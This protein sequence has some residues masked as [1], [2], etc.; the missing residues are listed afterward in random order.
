MPILAAPYTP[1]ALPPVVSWDGFAGMTWTGFNGDQWDLKGSAVSPSGV[2]LQRGARGLH[3]PQ[4]NRYSSSSPA[5]AGSRTRGHHTGDRDVFW[6][7]KVFRDGGSQAWMEYDRRFWATMA[8]DKP[9]VWTVIHPDGQARSL[10]CT[11]QHDG[12]GSFAI[13]PLLVGWA[14]YGL[15][16][17]A[18]QPYWEGS[19]I[20]R[21]WKASP[22]VDFFDPAGSPPFHIS[23]GSTFA[24]AVID[25]PGDVEAYP[26]WVLTGPT[27]SVAVGVDGHVVEYEVAIPEGQ[28]RTIDTR[29]DRL[30]VV[31]QDGVDRIDDLGAAEFVAVPAG[32]SVALDVAV[33]GTGMVEATIR[34]LFYR[35]W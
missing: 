26:V 17:V 27:T 6:P 35:A 21:T 16:L 8:P 11:A 20:V 25:N 3:F 34:P 24:T 9:G 30:T 5:V 18:E 10:T 7:L 32:A 29:P 14:L 23:S 33:A 19:P 13:D 4:V 15:N 12:D 28:T 1:P 22:P 2:T 31:D